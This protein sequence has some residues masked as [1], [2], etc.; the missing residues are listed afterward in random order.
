MRA[1]IGESSPGIGVA[2]MAQVGSFGKADD[3]K[4]MQGKVFVKATEG[5]PWTIH[6]GFKDF[7]IETN[8]ASD[9]LHREFVLMA[10]EKVAHKQAGGLG[11]YFRHSK[12][13]KVSEKVARSDKEKG[14]NRSPALSTKGVPLAE[15][16]GRV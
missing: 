6:S 4:A 7:P 9:E 10:L 2:E 15:A 16:N 13:G 3:L 1:K 12:G 5:Q 11:R 8:V 14:R